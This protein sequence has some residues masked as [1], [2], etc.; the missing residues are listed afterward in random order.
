MGGSLMKH[1]TL[2]LTFVSLSCSF[3]L[4]AEQVINCKN[5]KTM[6]LK[7]IDS[8]M[9]K[10]GNPL[11]MQIYDV[12]KYTWKLDIASVDITVSDGKFS[13]L[14]APQVCDKTIKPEHEKYCAIYKQ[15][16]KLFGKPVMLSQLQDIFGTAPSDVTRS[17]GAKYHWETPSAM[18]DISDE[19]GIIYP[20]TCSP[21]IMKFQ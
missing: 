21:I 14:D 10:L 4:F 13:A 7:S 5:L 20:P 18:I 15:V 2:L 6:N 3:P 8:A 9:E 11:S 17:K 16:E 19:N 1:I 12:V